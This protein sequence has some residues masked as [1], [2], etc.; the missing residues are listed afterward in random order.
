M[1]NDL[2]IRARRAADNL[3]AAV[4]DAELSFIPP[5][6]PARRRLL[7]AV[8]RPA[9]IVALLMI[10]S[11]VGV[12]MVIDSS[13]TATTAPPVATPTVVPATVAP[14]VPATIAP[15]PAPPTTAPAAVVVPPV[16]APVVEDTEPPLLEITSPQDGAEMEKKTIT[17]AGLTEPGARVFAGKY[18][19]DVDSE[20]NWHI[21]LVLSE[22]SNVGRFVARDPAGNESKASV[23]VYYVVPTT[24]TT[25][26]TPPTTEKE[27]AE[28]SANATFGSCSETPPYDVYS[29]TGEPGSLVE[30]TSEYGSGSVEVDG[31]GQW[32][33][34]VFFNEASPGVPFVV[35]VSDEFGRKKDFEFAY[36]P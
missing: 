1:S 25:E 23:T 33:K 6:T 10:G 35:R 22:G 4:S 26:P 15:E 31:E 2:D 24:T 32:E 27:L 5:G 36:T 18:E 30:I 12:A 29:G 17:F 9:W 21:V 20:G 3:K 34:K 16:S 11:A 19:A 28:F 14:T 7:F 13:P 8:L